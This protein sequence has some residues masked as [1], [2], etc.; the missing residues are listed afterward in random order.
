MKD[1]DS[2][3]PTITVLGTEADCEARY[4]SGLRKGRQCDNP[5][6][7]RINEI[8]YCNQHIRG[9]LLLFG[10]WTAPE[11][12]AL[13]TDLSTVCEACRRIYWHAELDM[14]KRAIIPWGGGRQHERLMKLCKSCHAIAI[15]CHSDSTQGDCE[16]EATMPAPWAHGE[17]QLNRIYYCA[18]CYEREKREETNELEALERRFADKEDEEDVEYIAPTTTLFNQLSQMIIEQ[19]LGVAVLD[20]HL[21]LCYDT[22]AGKME[23]IGGKILEG[24]L[25]QGIIDDN[26]ETNP[27]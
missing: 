21:W 9:Q 23:V 7:L 10:N 26:E 16:N 4:K 19:R 25:I 17:E 1:P 11:T 15:K 22:T 12:L 27:N 24:F 18:E 5:G 20:N 3:F 14:T 8:P 6:M 2:E 13:I